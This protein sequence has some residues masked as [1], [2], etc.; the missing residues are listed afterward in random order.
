[1]QS[2]A[3]LRVR[4]FSMTPSGDRVDW[5]EVV[6]VVTPAPFGSRIFADIYTCRIRGVSNGFLDYVRGVANGFL[7]QS[8]SLCSVI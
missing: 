3:N 5:I 1:V 2:F 4:R 6:D 7:D 8:G